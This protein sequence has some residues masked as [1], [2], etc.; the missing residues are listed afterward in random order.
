MVRGQWADLARMPGL[1]PY[2]FSEGHPGIFY[3]H[4]ESGPRFNVSYERRCFFDRIVS[5]SLYWGVKTHTDPRVSTLCWS[6]KHLFQQQPSFP[7]RSPIQVL[8]PKLYCISA[9]AIKKRPISNSFSAPSRC[10]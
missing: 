1:H 2:S 10:S 6:H 7:R 8:S 5:P 4:R 3:D 9:A